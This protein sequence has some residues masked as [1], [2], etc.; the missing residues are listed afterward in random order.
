MNMCSFIIF[1]IIT[2]AK[3]IK[4]S[5]PVDGHDIISPIL[6]SSFPQTVF[7]LAE[8][9]VHYYFVYLHPVRILLSAGFIYD[10][11]VIFLTGHI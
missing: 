3:I 4:V 2:L 6:G 5:F 9:G 8:E 1:L 7:V 11:Y 10:V